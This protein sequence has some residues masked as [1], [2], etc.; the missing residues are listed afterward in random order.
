M[1]FAV[2]RDAETSKIGIDKAGVAV[3]P[4]NGKILHDDCEKTNIDHVA[5]FFIKISTVRL[6]QF[7]LHCQTQRCKKVSFL[8]KDKRNLKFLGGNLVPLK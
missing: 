6:L 7:K 1:V 8:F 4:K 3:N 2:G 5:C